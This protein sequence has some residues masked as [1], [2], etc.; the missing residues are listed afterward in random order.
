[1]GLL[2]P[3]SWRTS[4]SVR[5]SKIRCNHYASNTTFVLPARLPPAWMRVLR[6][7]IGLAGGLGHY[8]FISRWRLWQVPSIVTLI[9]AV[10]LL[11]GQGANDVP[12]LMA[13]LH[14]ARWQSWWEMTR[15]S[16][17]PVAHHGLLHDLRGNVTLIPRNRLPIANR[18]STH[19]NQKQ[20]Q[21]PHHALPF[22]DFLEHGNGGT[23]TTTRQTSPR[24]PA[25]NLTYSQ[26]I[27]C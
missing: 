14:A 2:T 5:K 25:T 11:H 12:I 4:Y 8:P 9:C 24:R 21:K 13:P 22:K 6:R 20:H 17:F 23:P 27:S 3:L 10:G 19:Q 7:I 15:T 18:A 1:M 16:D 26:E